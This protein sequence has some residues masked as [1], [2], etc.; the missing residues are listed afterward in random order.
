MAD[1]IDR[2]I[3]EAAARNGIP[4]ATLRRYVQIESNFNPNAKTGSYKG[5][6]Q[7][8]DSE[9]RKHG[10]RG[11]IF[12]PAEN[13]SAGAAKLAAER[14]M[15]MQRY[16]RE[17]STGELYLIHQQGWGGLQAHLANPDR[18]AWQSMASTGEGR[19][20]GE[21]W[22]KLAISG[23]IPRKWG[24]DPETITSGEFVRRWS[25]RAG[26]QVPT[27]RIQPVQT[28]SI[29]NSRDPQAPNTGWHASVAPSEPQESDGTPTALDAITAALAAMQRPSGGSGGDGGAHAY[30][31]APSM[32]QRIAVALLP[33][34]P[35]ATLMPA[36]KPIKT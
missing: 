36:A 3:A 23:N 14:R 9:F 33:S 13:L 8:S 19:A 17:P 28:A 6:L 24:V 25:E 4:E 29:A 5:L 31:P 20:K 18:P 27:Q 26:G 32:D 15:F 2:L 35:V 12:D 7:L 34:R 1:N 30:Q 21:K 16:G 10:G 22:A 11:N